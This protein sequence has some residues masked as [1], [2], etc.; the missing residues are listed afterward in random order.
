MSRKALLPLALLLL[1]PGLLA[2]ASPAEAGCEYAHTV[3]TTYYAF[4]DPSRWQTC[5]IPQ[6]SPVIPYTREAIGEEVFSECDD[7]YSSWGDTTT[8]TG[9]E[10]VEVHS[11]VCGLICG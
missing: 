10:N 6:V 11:S 3:R 5:T 2:L 1:V 4:F 9:E 8:C 7:S